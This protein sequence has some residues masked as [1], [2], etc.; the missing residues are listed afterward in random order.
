LGLLLDS[1]N[2]IFNEEVFNILFRLEV[3]VVDIEILKGE[4]VQAYR[5]GGIAFEALDCLLLKWDL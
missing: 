4:V 1:L 2:I 5:P 3:E